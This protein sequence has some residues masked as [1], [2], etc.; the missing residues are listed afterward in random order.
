VCT[1]LKFPS[2]AYRKLTILL[3]DR[4]SLAF[5]SR[6]PDPLSMLLHVVAARLCSNPRDKIFGLLGLLPPELTR[7]I[8]PQYTDS[9][10]EVFR[11]ATIAYIECT[12]SLDIL[13]LSGPSWIPDWSVWRSALGRENDHCGSNSTAEVS[14]V[15]SDVLM[16]TGASFDSI[17]AVG[18]RIPTV[19]SAKK[20]QDIIRFIYHLW[21]KGTS[22]HQTY[23]TGESIA[24]ACAWTIN[25]GILSDRW[26]K[27]L[28]GAVTL[29]EAQLIFQQILDLDQSGDS[30]SNYTAKLH[31]G[32]IDGF[33]FC[34][35][36]GY[37]GICF[38]DV[39][40]GDEV[41]VFLGC[42]FA[43]ILRPQP[44]DKYLFVGC[45]YVHGIMDG[46][47]L[48]G[49]LPP[50]WKAV[51]RT[52]VNGDQQQK[53]LNT[54]GEETLPDPRFGEL[55]EEWEAIL[56]P[57]RVWPEKEVYVARHRITG[58][59]VYSDPRLLPDALRARGVSL[60]QFALV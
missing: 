27:Q 28:N 8:Q 53:I 12:G 46:E 17:V 32:H 35:A 42:S 4:Y 55:A 36:K 24:E 5:A 52:D 31:K 47:A 38:N 10:R 59:L 34:T 23:P 44:D 14:C 2:P 51:I 15:D 30:E 45:A 20:D 33:L 16:V 7:R 29:A 22:K 56:A 49:P 9:P 40:P 60:R 37:F 57:D 1:G 11:K 6:Y 13:S 25:S 39:L 3:G 43:A 41:S 19:E 21:L 50:G 48:L 26:G 54:S 58:Q 18:G